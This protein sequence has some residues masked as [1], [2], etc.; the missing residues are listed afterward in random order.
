MNRLIPLGLGTI[1]ASGDALVETALG[2]P[3]SVVAAASF[4]VLATVSTLVW[5]VRHLLTKTIPGLAQAHTAQVEKVCAA[6]D[7]QVDRTLQSALAMHRDLMDR[8]PRP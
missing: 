4:V 8:L 5:V 1:F 2:H 7:R 3:P 6:F